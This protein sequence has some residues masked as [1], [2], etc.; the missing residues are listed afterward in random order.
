MKQR[1]LNYAVVHP[2]KPFKHVAIHAMPRKTDGGGGEG[3]ESLG[4]H[5][6]L[7]QSGGQR[8]VGPGVDNES[9]G[10]AGGEHV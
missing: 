4:P 5:K 6:I 3:P 1:K 2:N 8:D 7:E 10:F 9:G